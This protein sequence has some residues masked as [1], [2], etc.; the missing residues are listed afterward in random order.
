MNN[1]SN[2]NNNKPIIKVWLG[3]DGIIYIYLAGQLG[4]E[5]VKRFIEEK[6]KILKEIKGK[7]KT[8]GDLR[9]I[10]MGNFSL[11]TKIKKMMVSELKE[12]EQEKVE[13]MALV[14]KGVILKVIGS[15]LG[16]ALGIKETKYFTDKE[17]ALKWLKEG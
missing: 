15:F 5:E 9:D 1:Q 8:F 3:E 14:G 13:K 4:E 6:I 16:K 12:L 17:K 11:A 2:K 10:K 7:T